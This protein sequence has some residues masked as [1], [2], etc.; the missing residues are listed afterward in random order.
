MRVASLFA[1][2]LVTTSFLTPPCCAQQPQQR[3]PQQRQP[4]QRQPQQRQ[5]QQRGRLVQGILDNLVDTQ[6]QIQPQ[7]ATG[8]AIAPQQAMQ[9]LESF[10][11]EA[12][13]LIDDLRYE[14]RFSSY[15]RALLGD[16]VRVKAAA[17]ILVSR[18]RTLPAGQFSTEYAELDRGWRVLAYRIRQTP[19]MGGALLRRVERLDQ[20]SNDLGQ[21]LK[22]APQLQRD[23]LSRSFGTL[24][25]HLNRLTEDVRFDLNRH[26]R[27]NQF[28]AQIRS[29][30]D[31]SRQLRLLVD[32]R[33][34]A[35]DI[36]KYYRQFQN[37]WQPL[38]NELRATGQQNILRSIQQV[39][40]TNDYLQELL[41]IVPQH[42]N[43]EI[44]YQADALMRSVDAVS[45]SIS[46]KGLLLLPNAN[47]IFSNSKEVYSLCSDFQQSVRAD[48]TDLESLRWDFRVLDVAWNDLKQ[49][50]AS[51]NSPDVA[52]RVTV[53]D[54]S[55]AELRK[56]IGMQPSTNYEQTAQLV[57]ALDNMTDLFHQDIRRTVGQSGQYSAQFRDG[58]V[59]ASQTF[60]NTAHTLHDSLMQN[61]SES[62]LQQQS[63]LLASQWNQLQQYVSQTTTSDQAQLY[64]TY[65]TIAPA[66]AKLQVMH[67]Y[68]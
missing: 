26:P 23:E 21:Q 62:L 64:R 25:G 24:D 49:H 36:V 59:Q 15:V 28:A 47:R 29:L 37:A 19:D 39:T 27:R 5:P 12:G 30:Q 57:S 58:A 50:L 56:A 67:A 14:E 61:I 7:H 53:I 46:L 22:L 41:W 10:A 9:T 44:R 63:Q 18:S 16:A 6:I 2:L 17:D 33:Y 66:V 60:H 8:S 3:Q 32:G 65:Q 68:Y 52:P 35:D 4:Q 55:V 45:E 13:K 48:S 31:R 34:S 11:S 51:L 42:D 40:Q 54:N 38:K 20:L 1:L 43:R